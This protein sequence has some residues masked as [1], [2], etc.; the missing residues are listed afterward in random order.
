M[1][2]F[3]FS[4]SMQ[5]VCIALGVV[6]VSLISCNSQRKNMD[7]V[8]KKINN[9]VGVF[10][11]LMNPDYVFHLPKSLDEISGICCYNKNEIVCVQDEKAFL[12]IFDTAKEAVVLKNDFGKKADYEDVAIDGDTAYVLSSNGNIFKVENF[13]DK[14]TSKTTKLKTSL[15]KK[16]DTEGLFF[17]KSTNSLLIACKGSPSIKDSN[18]FEGL[19]AI[20]RFDLGSNTLIEKPAYLVDLNNADSAMFS[21]AIEKFLMDRA[22]K[23]ELTGEDNSLFPSGIAIN[24]VDNENIYILSAVGNLLI[25]MN[26]YGSI[27]KIQQL[28]NQI[29]N[30]PE[31]ICFSENGDMYIS[32]EGKKGTANIL[33]FTAVHVK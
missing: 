20:Y 28:D 11:D 10:Y 3:G 30:Q 29:F 16:N 15:N 9:T 1:H 14:T 4:K 8:E 7:Q 17:Q 27:I 31:G 26:K 25:I 22:V 23:L 2:K 24:P 21:G 32:N 5:F 13:H 6:S 19:K 12:Y 18:D 33:K